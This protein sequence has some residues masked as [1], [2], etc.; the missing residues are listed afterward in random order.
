MCRFYRAT[1]KM[2]VKMTAHGF[3]AWTFSNY[4]KISVITWK[5]WAYRLFGGIILRGA[6]LRRGFVIGGNFAFHW[7][8]LDNKNSLKHED[9]SLKQLSLTVYRLIFGRA[10][11]RKDI[12]V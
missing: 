5:P 2:G 7:V 8:G 4:R 12:C 1:G 6:Y 11:Y 9:N 3:F 10:H